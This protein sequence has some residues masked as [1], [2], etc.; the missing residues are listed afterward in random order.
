M[1]QIGRCNC[2]AIE[3]ELNDDVHQALICY[4]K[5][6]QRSSSSHSLSFNTDIDRIRVTRGEPKA[7]DSTV[8]GSGKP[9]RRVFC[10]EC[11]TNLWTEPSTFE[12]KAFV[13]VGTLDNP[14]NGKVE[15]VAEVFC[16]HAFRPFEPSPSFGQVQCTQGP[17][18]APFR[19]PERRATAL[20]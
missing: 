4:C 9:V 19:Q 2:D 1:V 6:C 10:P 13:K 16:D 11:G 7:W 15:L 18:S 17:G 8:S 12:G 3:Y 14:G 20:Q 5:A